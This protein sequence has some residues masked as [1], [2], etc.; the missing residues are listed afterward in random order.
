MRQFAAINR[1]GVPGDVVDGKLA[2]VEVDDAASITSGR[3]KRGGVALFRQHKL[4][5][6]NRRRENP[7]TAFERYVAKDFVK[8]AFE[9]RIGASHRKLSGRT[10]AKRERNVFDDKRF[11]R[12]GG[13]RF[14]RV[15][16]H[17]RLLGESGKPKR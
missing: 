8:V 14:R 5:L 17:F 2:R 6:C 7:K 4:T 13:A 1:G 3:A 11:D 15:F 9:F 10:P 16:G 12:S